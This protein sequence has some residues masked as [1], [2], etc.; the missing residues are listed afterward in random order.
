MTATYCDHCKRE[1]PV[2]PV[3]NPRTKEVLMLCE[4]CAEDF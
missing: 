2:T 1:K 3:V 4:E